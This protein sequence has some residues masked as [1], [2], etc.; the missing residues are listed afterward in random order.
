[1]GHTVRSWRLYERLAAK[2]R[3]DPRDV[4]DI[5]FDAVNP[6]RRDIVRLALH[7]RDALH[8]DLSPDAA[9]A[10]KVLDGW[11]ADG[12]SSDLTHRG[13]ALAGEVSTFF[14]F[15][16]TPLAGR[17]GGGET[18]ICRFLR[19]ATARIARDPGADLDPQERQYLDQA[20]SGAWRSARQKYGDDP[21]RWEDRAREQVRRGRLGA[22][23][24]L[25]GFG[26][27]DPGAEIA[28]AG[29][30]CVDGGTIKSQAAQSYTQYVP[31]HDVDAALSLLPPGHSERPDDPLRTST[32]PLWESCQ[33]HPA[34][35]SRAAVDRV[36]AGTRVLSPGR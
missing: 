13:A 11:D 15:I 33:L 30:T 10:L 21:A 31:L 27:L 28:V 3:F 18:G 2:P 1:M 25:D 22:F 32:V 34:P 17:Y 8:A 19:N 9:D 23:D 36:A 24:T 12:A 4:L 6:A 35:L 26:P 16:N 20:L 5:H 7:L 14:R 29:L